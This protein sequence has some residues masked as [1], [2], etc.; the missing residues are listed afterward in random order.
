MYELASNR[1]RQGLALVLE[2][3]LDAVAAALERV[4]G[5]LGRPAESLVELGGGAVADLAD[6]PGD[7]QAAMGTADRAVVVATGEVRVGPDGPDLHGAQADLLGRGRR[8]HGDDDGPVHPVG[9]VTHHSRARIPP[10]EPPTTPAQ[11]SM[12]SRSARA[13]STAHLVPDGDH[14]EARAV[15]AG[16][17]R[18]GRPGRSC[19]GS[20]RAHW[21]RPRSSG[22][23]RSAR[24]GPISA[25]H[26]PAVGWPGPAGPAA[27][28]SPVRACRTRT[29]LSAVP[30]R[31]PQVS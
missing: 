14:R 5:V 3:G 25:S 8:A 10:I 30:L 29:A 6:A 27:W 31:S 1:G 20:H 19:P 15:A 23:C 21:G 18:P 9:A 2:I 24:P 4:L 22:R 11:R 26:H 12:P 7:G 13:T 28:E 17:R 16:R